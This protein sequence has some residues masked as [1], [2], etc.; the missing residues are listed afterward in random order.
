MQCGPWFCYS[1]VLLGFIHSTS[2]I[3]V[4][5][6]DYKKSGMGKVCLGTGNLK[7]EGTGSSG[8]ACLETGK[9]HLK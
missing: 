9:E 8:P 7:K 2:I 3:K 6:F 5:V 4:Q 1:P